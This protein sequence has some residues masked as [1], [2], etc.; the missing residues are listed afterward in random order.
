MNW[1]KDSDPYSDAEN[2]EEYWHRIENGFE[3]LDQVAQDG[4]KFLFINHGMTIMSLAEK[5]GDGSFEITDTPNNSTITKLTRDSKTNTNIVNE[6]A[7]DLS[8]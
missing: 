2:A 6:Y 8:K 3:H 4:D 1:M 7:K 5:Y